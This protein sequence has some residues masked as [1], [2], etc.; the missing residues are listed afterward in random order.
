MSP[1]SNVSGHRFRSNAYFFA[2]MVLALGATAP[3]QGQMFSVNPKRETIELPGLVL[4]VGLERTEVSYQGAAVP[5][6][7][8]DFS[9]SADLLR[10]QLETG[11]LALSYSR[12][13]SL[14]AGNTD[15]SS[16]EVALASAFPITRRDP[17]QISIPFNFYSV[18]TIMSSRQAQFSNS[19]FRQN[20]LGLRTGLQ[21]QL[22]L[23]PRTRIVAFGTGGYA[24]SANGLNSNGG[25]VTQWDAGAR[26]HVDGLIRSA[27]LTAGMMLH[28]RAYDVDVRAYNYDI[29]SMSFILGVTF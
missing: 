18:Y 27:G 6:P 22:R 21:T 14:G 24:F 7:F 11:G 9:F 4:A 15:Y 1:A 16:F 28:E 20:A 17:V 19:E 10:F 3:V 5:P 2:L 13:S 23:N 12:G 25:S 29:R 8:A 26:L